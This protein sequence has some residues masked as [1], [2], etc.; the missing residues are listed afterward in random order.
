MDILIS[1]LV[2]TAVSVVVNSIYM[3]MNNAKVYEV[4][5]QIDDLKEQMTKVLKGL[6]NVLEELDDISLFFAKGGR[7]DD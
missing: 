7:E 5:R 1:I 3:A 4:Q 2:P 6:E